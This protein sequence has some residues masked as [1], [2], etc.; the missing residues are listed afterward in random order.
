MGVGAVDAI[1]AVDAG[2]KG[3]TEATAAAGAA[4]DADATAGAAADAD[5]T[6]G[7]A[8]EGAGLIASAG[9]PA[10][11]T[12][13]G[14]PEAPHAA[15]RVAPSASHRDARAP[16]HR[17]CT[18]ALLRKGPPPTMR[19]GERRTPWQAFASGAFRSQATQWLIPLHPS[20]DRCN[21]RRTPGRALAQAQRGRGRFHARLAAPQ[22][23][24]VGDAAV[25]SNSP[26]VPQGGS[27]TRRVDLTD[28]EPPRPRVRSR[29]RRAATCYWAAA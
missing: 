8:A 1:G 26:A 10:G 18:N 2:G 5:A 21:R 20:A 28:Q 29:S 11:A 3:A 12:G 14:V 17:C 19:K 13:V 9:V 7:A 15:R 22:V 23:S 25:C 4:A 27:I 6:A 16:S 24:T